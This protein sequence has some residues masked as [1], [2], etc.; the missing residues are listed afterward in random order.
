MRLHTVGEVYCHVCMHPNLTL[1]QRLFGG[2]SWRN[3]SKSLRECKAS[4]KDLRS[5]LD[6]LL[7]EL[8]HRRCQVAQNL[9]AGKKVSSMLMLAETKKAAL[10]KE[11]YWMLLDAI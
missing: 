2:T 6:A 7:W 4:L 8:F 1:S 9:H 11:I 5:Y 10:N 3:Y